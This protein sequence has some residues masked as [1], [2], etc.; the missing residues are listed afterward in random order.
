[1]AGSFS[2]SWAGPLPSLLSV[3]SDVDIEDDEKKYFGFGAPLNTR[4]EAK[5]FMHYIQNL[6]SWFD[7]CDPARHFSIEVPKRAHHLPL[8]AYS[9]LAYSSRQV[10]LMTGVDKESHSSYYSHALRILIPIFDNPSEAFNENVLAAIVIL[11]SYEEMFEGDVNTHLTGS[12]KLLNSESRFVAQGGLG[13]AASWV[14]LRQDQYVCLTK[15]LPLRINL[16]SYENSQAFIDSTD[17]S[18]A[19][20]AVFICG[21][22]IA[23][24]MNQSL[25]LDPDVWEELD[26]ETK[27][28]HKLCPWRFLSSESAATGNQ[29]DSSAFPTLWMP[30]KV[31]VLGL[32]HYFLAR[33]IL[34]I[35]HPKLWKPS[36]EAFGLRTI[37]QDKGRESLRMLLGLA[38]S[39]QGDATIKFTAHHTLHACGGFLRDAREHQEVLEFLRDM[40]ATMGWPTQVLAEKLRN[41]WQQG[42]RKTT[43]PSG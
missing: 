5:Y 17:H 37:A 23:Y 28:W 33:M 25:R 36:F 35:F 20:R 31:Q 6:G 9:I 13:E 27:R 41:Q 11:R 22:V 7:T 32:Q 34:D 16:D 18:L 30:R 39:N 19:N 38:I 2:L 43:E 14:V 29:S 40:T 21:R 15:S 12:S 1:M 8:L 24:A 26:Q 42:R 4:K 3:A 10:S